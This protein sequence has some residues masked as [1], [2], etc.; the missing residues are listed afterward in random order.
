MG[1]SLVP[2]LST[3]QKTVKLFTL[4][5]Y[6]QHCKRYFRKNRKKLTYLLSEEVPEGFIERQLNDSRYIS[7]FVKSLLGNLISARR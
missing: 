3:K 7:K 4:D 6:E 5:E 1:G 2:E